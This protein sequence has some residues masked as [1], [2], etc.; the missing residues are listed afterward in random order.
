MAGTFAEWA[1]WPDREEVVLVELTPA[2]VLS[3]W[4]AVGG[5]APNSYQVSCPA[6]V[7]TSQVTGGVYR[8]V[9]GL[10]ENGT[11]LTERASLAA[12]DANA[13]SWF[14]DEAAGL[15]YTRTSSGG[16]PDTFTV[17]SALVRFYLA[18]TGIVLDRIDGSPSTGI[19]HQPWLVGDVPALVQEI[20]DVLFGIKVTASGQVSATNA[21]GFWHTVIAPDGAYVWKN[22]AVTVY[23]GGRYRDQSLARSEYQAVATML[24]EDVV[25][26]ELGVSWL[27][28]PLARLTDQSIPPTPYF[29][30]SYPNM[31]DGVR[32]TRKWI[33]YGRAWIA[34]DLTDTSGRGVYTIADAAYQ[35]LY[36]VH[37]VHA[38]ETDGGGGRRNLTHGQD[39]S[40]DLTACT[41]TLLTDVYTW[42]THRIEVEVTGKPGGARGYLSTFAEIVQDLLTTHL[43][44]PAGDLDASAWTAAQ[45]DAPEELACWTKESRS[46]ASILGTRESGFPSLEGS[47]NGAVLQTRDGKWTARIWK[48]TYTAAGMVSLRKEDLAVFRPE[49]KIDGA[50]YTTVQVH[51][52]YDHG[53]AE[54]AVQTASDTRMQHLT[55]SSDRLELYTY[56]RSAGDAETLAKRYQFI[57]SRNQ[58]AVA[59]EERGSLLAD[60]DAGDR[61]FVTHSPAPVASGAFTDRLCEITRLERRFSPMFRVSGVLEDLDALDNLP[62][63]VGEWTGPTADNWAA[64]DATERLGQGFWCDANGRADSGDPA[65]AGVSRWW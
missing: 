12:C 25:C 62:R 42:R 13:G 26:D 61:V 43:G 4:T 17:F 58:L 65:S 7:G 59:F 29:E 20:E 23:L 24:V 44:V 32:G 19:Y 33:G 57:V 60:A 30:A 2:L 47:V 27:L 64:A 6:L 63:T 15:L 36:R 40:V 31:G 38:V 48:P 8:R 52:D 45:A 49:P 18:T 35:T 14:W 51:H 55:G 16:D 37:A 41:L 50:V 34:P 54:W 3:G 11:A 46:I 9:V 21:H 5:G 22:R 28:K 53:V 56:L 1:T 10:R 39:F